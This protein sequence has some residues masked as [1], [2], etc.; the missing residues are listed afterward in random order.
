MYFFFLRIRRPPRFTRTDTLFPHT[1]LYRSEGGG[2]GSTADHDPHPPQDHRAALRHAD[3]LHGIAGER[4]HHL[5]AWPGGN[6]Q[7]LSGGGAGGEP[8]CDRKSVV[9]GQS[10]SVRVDLGGRRII[11]TK[12]KMS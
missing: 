12:I 10:V 4:R 7:D 11:K 1:T 5:R 3:P 8:A 9:S 2:R 6:G